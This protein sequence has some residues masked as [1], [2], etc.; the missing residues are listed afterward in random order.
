MSRPARILIGKAGMDNHDRG[1]IV[2]SR[3]LRDAGFEV[4][5]IGSGH[6]P[7]ELAQ[8]AVD[9]DVAAIGLSLL[10]GAHVEILTDLRAALDELG[11]EDIALFAGGII[12]D[13][14]APALEQVGVAQ[15]YTPG[16]P[17]SKIVAGVSELVGVP[18]D[19]HST[20]GR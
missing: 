9:E 1:A 14:D 7:G 18:T 6:T 20:R 17:L 10:S 2:V 16:T 19:R 4:V 11:A 3:A 5:Y 8:V 12:P 15:T 13:E